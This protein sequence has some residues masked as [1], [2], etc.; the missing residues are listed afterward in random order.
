MRHFIFLPAAAISIALA[1]GIALV[2]V[3][4]HADPP[5]M[6]SVTC[7]SGGLRE[8]PKF[9]QVSPGRAEYRFSGVCVTLDGMSLGYRLDG[10]WTPSEGG[11]NANASEI[12]HVD[13]LSGPSQ[14]Y[15]AAVGWR[16][17]QDPWLHVVECQRV[18][19]DIPEGLRALWNRFAEG[20]TFPFSSRAIPAGQR[21]SL[22]DR[23]ERAN[24]RSDRSQMLADHVRIIDAGDGRGGRMADKVALNPQPLPPRTANGAARRGDAVS[25]NPQ[26]LPPRQSQP[27]A[28]GAP[29]RGTEAGIIIVS[30]KASYRGIGTKA[31]LPAPDAAAPKPVVDTPT[32]L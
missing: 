1:S 9:T 26:P 11:G 17:P 6:P 18:G 32:P 23:Y 19:D 28:A 14:S 21:Q 12:Y 2:P 27:T 24:G 3:V 8:P 5:R 7:T 25:L 31:A 16:C 15:I 4:A 30:G 29:E 13:T 10:T 22:I 20:T